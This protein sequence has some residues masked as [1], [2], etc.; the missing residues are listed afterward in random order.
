MPID[1]KKIDEWKRLAQFERSDGLDRRELREMAGAA[2][3]LLSEREEMLSLLRELEWSADHD[4]YPDCCPICHC[5]EPKTHAPDCRLAALLHP[6][7]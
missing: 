6:A 3:A 4:E 5:A 7:A 1:P 2:L